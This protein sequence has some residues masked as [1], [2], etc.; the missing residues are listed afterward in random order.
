MPE[1]Q[2]AEISVRYQVLCDATAMVGVI[3][4]MDPAKGKLKVHEF[5]YDK[6]SKAKDSMADNPQLSA[7][8]QSA[9][10]AISR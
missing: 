2:Q 5:N 10:D 3:E 9:M 8:A 1:H 4:E 7:A 6:S